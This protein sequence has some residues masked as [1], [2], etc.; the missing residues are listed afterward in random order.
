MKTNYEGHFKRSI[1]TEILDTTTFY[2]AEEYHQ[3]YK[4]KNP[5][6][7]NRYRCSCGRDKRL[8]EIWGNE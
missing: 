3:D 6:S 7:Y 8:K 2:D 4:A 5:V 1:T